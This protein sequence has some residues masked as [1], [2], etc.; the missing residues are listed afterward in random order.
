MAG[1]PQASVYGL[2]AT[3]RNREWEYSMNFSRFVAMGALLHIAA[4][5]ATAQLV[6]VTPEVFTRMRTL[7]EAAKTKHPTSPGK[8]D[9]EFAK[10]VERTFGEP[11]PG[12]SY[13]VSLDSISVY[14]VTPLAR[15][16]MQF[17]A[18]L[19]ELAALPAEFEGPDDAVSL[20]IFPRTI[21]APNIKGVV[22]FSGTTPIEVT[23]HLKEQEF[24]TRMGAK[25]RKF[26]GDVRIPVSAFNPSA[27]LKLILQDAGPSEFT[28]SPAQLRRLR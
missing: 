15:A 28:L 11:R 4:G 18:A 7:A 20:V 21:T 12:A 23:S 5:V 6:T 22:V 17:S 13:I 8:A 2:T 9:D 14:L 3:V 16:Q 27:P 1:E 25:A 19:R 24:E 10:Q 26:I